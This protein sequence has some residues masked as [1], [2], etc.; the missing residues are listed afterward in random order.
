MLDFFTNCSDLC[1]KTVAT[2]RRTMYISWSLAS[3]FCPT[4]SSSQ[5]RTTQ[6]H[7]EIFTLTS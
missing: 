1:Q 2:S 6:K 7:K 4:L 3:K 5:D